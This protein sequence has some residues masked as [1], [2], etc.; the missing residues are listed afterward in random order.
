MCPVCHLGMS[1]M[2]A[3]NAVL[4]IF[5]DCI[6]LFGNVNFMLITVLFKQ[7]R[8]N[9]CALLMGMVSFCDA[10]LEI[11]IIVISA[12]LLSGCHFYQHTCFYILAI[13]IFLNCVQTGLMFSISVER[14]IAVAWP[15]WYQ[16]VQTT[17]LFAVSFVPGTIFGGLVVITGLVYIQANETIP[18]CNVPVSLNPTAYELWN[19]ISLGVNVVMI[20]V[21]VVACVILWLKARKSSSDYI[22]TQITV[23]KTIVCIVIFYII[24]WV[25]PD[26][27]GLA[28]AMFSL[29]AEVLIYAPSFFAHLCF[30]GNFYIYMWRNQSYRDCF[31]KMYVCDC[32]HRNVSFVVSAMTSSMRGPT[33]T[34]Q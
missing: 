27:I 6:G 13:P 28:K 16:N 1:T 20:V 11:V 31:K 26:F 3:Y 4:L 9:V 32:R 14:L 21:Y 8:M 19:R 34:A 2:T 5:V 24:T 33:T 25:L 17:L 22:K 15:L 18:T 23:M 10:V 7:F 29:E 12:C 30:T